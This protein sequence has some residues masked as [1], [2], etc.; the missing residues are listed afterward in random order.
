MPSVLVG[1]LFELPGGVIGVDLDRP[2]TIPRHQ[3]ED[4][5]IRKE[6]L[7]IG[8]FTMQVV[9]GSLPPE[10]VQHYDLFTGALAYTPVKELLPA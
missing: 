4:W 2:I 9:R 6:A 1:R 8:G 7:V 3:V 10:T 5:H